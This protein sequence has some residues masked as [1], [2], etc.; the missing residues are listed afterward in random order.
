[1][2]CLKVR[3]L[4]VLPC[5]LILKS[6]LVLTLVL[7]LA[8]CATQPGYQYGAASAQIKQLQLLDTGAPVRN[9]GISASLNGRYGENVLSG[10]VESTYASKSGRN[11]TPQAANNSH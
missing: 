4:F 2:S 1:M 10:Y 9:D 11:I 6:T 3:C 5:A 8:G 7:T